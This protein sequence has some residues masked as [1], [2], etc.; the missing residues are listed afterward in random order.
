MCGETWYR[1]NMFESAE[2]M[3][4]RDDGE[5]AVV[6]LQV[7]ERDPHRALPP[8]GRGRECR[9]MAEK[10]KSLFND[11]HLSEIKLEDNNYLPKK[12]KMLL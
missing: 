2:A 12:Y 7:T 6:D 9:R 10:R 1:G 3:A 5:H 11:N 8:V 4:S